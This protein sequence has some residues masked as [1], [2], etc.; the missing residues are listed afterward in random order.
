MTFVLAA[1]ALLR[2]RPSRPVR[3]YLLGGILLTAAPLLLPPLYG[4]YTLP[5]GAREGYHMLWLTEPQ[6]PFASAFKQAQ[7]IHEKH[8]CTYYLLGWTEDEVL[9]YRSACD[10]RLWAFDPATDHA[11]Y[12]VSGHPPAVA[13]SSVVGVNAD[14]VGGYYPAHPAGFPPHATNHA[15]TYQRAISPQGRWVAAAI[16]NYYGPRDVVVLSR[17]PSGP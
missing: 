15:I 5:V 12:V 1:L 4:D 8:G 16:K 10:G 6:R 2:A 13:G 3:H 9:Y 17:S 14:G 11:P 7:R